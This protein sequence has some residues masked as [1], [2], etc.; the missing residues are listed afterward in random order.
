M[1][2]LGLSIFNTM[3]DFFKTAGEVLTLEYMLY[4]FIGLELLTVIIFSIIVSNVYELKL[5]RAIDRI[6]SYLYNA[7]YIDESNLIEFNNKMKKVPKTLRYHWQQFMLYR[8]KSP[9]YYMSI[10]NCIDRPI[11][12]SFFSTN[13]KLVK[14]IGWVLAILS[15]FLAI[16]GLATTGVIDVSFY[17]SAL[18]IPVIILT[19]NYIFASIL[20]LKQSTNL[21]DLY[22]TF[23]IFNRFIDK[24]VTSLPEYVDYEV[25]FTRKE[26]KKGIPVLNEY[27][28]KRQIQEQEEMK[29]ARQNAVE[30]EQFNFEKADEK[31][32][33][34]LERAMKET[35]TYINLKHRL[36]AEIQQLEG[37]IESYKR[38]Y[39]NT[40]K[41]YQK[42]L[43]A[44]KE[45]IDRLREQQEGTTNRIESNYIRKQQSDEIKKQ[46]QIEKD[47]DDA[48]LRFNQEINTL[49][50]EIDKR[51]AE[52][53]EGKKY[54]EKAMMAEYS[55]FANKIFAEVKKDVDN[56]T[57]D[58]REEL[59]NSREM[60]V[61]ELE[62]ALA[63]QE[64]LEK[65]NQALREKLGLK[66]I[67]MNDK[68][69]KRDKELKNKEQYYSQIL[70]E[71]AEKATSGIANI[72]EEPKEEPVYDEYGGY[73]DEEGYYRYQN[74]TY[75]DPDGNYHDEFGGVIDADGTY[76]PA[77]EFKKEETTENADEARLK[78]IEDLLNNYE[79]P[80]QPVEE[81][82]E[83]EPTETA[84]KP[85]AQRGRPKKVISEEELNK[86]KAGRGRPRKEKTEEDSKPK[87]QR[88]RPKKV[89]S[90]E[91]LNKPKAGRGRP[92]K[93]KTEEELNKPKGKRGRPRKEEMDKNLQEIEEKIKKEN[94]ILK[95]KQNDLKNSVDNISNGED[96]K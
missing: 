20:R 62:D 83:E 51:K 18:M 66:D 14:A 71:T 76:H 12:S 43:Q 11:K 77:E 89:V 50:A 85:K 88:G 30:H 46:Q 24:A 54:V 90:E 45:N 38:S 7:Q 25:L 40:S 80:N 32:V 69:A 17:L 39:E 55:T 8:E 75:Y 9:S 63:K 94:E 42:K 27:I 87:G 3:V 29:K 56:K 23:H 95:S 84:E 73:Y 21:S 58:E 28:E 93:E 57:K 13:I 37:E 34:V 82:T 44:S 35:E 65:D 47:Q 81:K 2:F 74:G 91:E 15:G 26:I 59:L 78:E 79:D 16:A 10:E 86:P 64:T 4:I 96:N 48:T 53:E 60:V 31:G 41:D 36:M 70:K 5:I 6:N 61:S 68:L 1:S 22:Q 52:L 49:T 33:L 67:E 72:S 19:V 92:R